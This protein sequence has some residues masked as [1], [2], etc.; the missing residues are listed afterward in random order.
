MKGVFNSVLT[1]LWSLMLLGMSG[2]KKTGGGLLAPELVCLNNPS[3]H[4]STEHLYWTPKV[5]GL[6]TS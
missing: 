5:T 2:E 3:V 4:F 6:N 1:W